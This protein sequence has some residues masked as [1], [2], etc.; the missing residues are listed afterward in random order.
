MPAPEFLDTNVLV[1][2][3]DPGDPH[4]QRIAQ[5]LV[6]R[7]LTGDILVRHRCWRNLRPPFCTRWQPA[8]RPGDVAAVLDALGPIGV[9]VPDADVV[10]RAVEVRA[11]YGVHFYD[12]MIVAAAERG[13]CGAD[14]VGGSE[15]GPR[16]LR[17]CCGEPLPLIDTNKNLDTAYRRFLKERE[18]LK[19]EEA[20]WRR[21]S[22][23]PRPDSSG[24]FLDVPPLNSPWASS[25]RDPRPVAQPAP[26]GSPVRGRGSLGI[27]ASVR[28]QDPR[29]LP[30]E[31]YPS[32]FH[33]EHPRLR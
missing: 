5:G 21:H 22:C 14:L 32:R 25:R 27:P 4:K 11:E 9:V 7:A 30:R 20:P 19:K 17:N 1:Y 15:R 28:L 12:G 3:Y 18:P 23:L 31:G 2:A 6:R 13:G 24:R 33:R 10:R 29:R 8:A 26:S 16:V